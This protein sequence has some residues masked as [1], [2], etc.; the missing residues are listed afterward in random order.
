[1][2]F[3]HAVFDSGSRPGE[4]VLHVD[5]IRDLGF[6]CWIAARLVCDDSARPVGARGG[7][8]FEETLRGGLITLLLQQDIRFGTMLI[9]GAPQHIRL[10]GHVDEVMA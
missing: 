5:Q 10:A 7:H 8:A 2:I 4:D 6:R 3:L 9:D 1:M